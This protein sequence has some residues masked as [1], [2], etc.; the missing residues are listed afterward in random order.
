VRTAEIDY[1]SW[2]IGSLTTAAARATTATLPLVQTLL[3]DAYREL[4]TLLA[5]DA[6]ALKPDIGD[7]LMVTLDR[8]RQMEM[9]A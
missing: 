8:H 1:Y 9:S 3:I 4:F 6:N 2:L 7:D 5:H